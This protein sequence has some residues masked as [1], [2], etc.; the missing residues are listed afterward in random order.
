MECRW[1]LETTAAVDCRVGLQTDPMYHAMLASVNASATVTMQAV[2]V[3]D[4]AVT[5]QLRC[6]YAAMNTS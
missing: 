5:L 4:A 3:A 2:C 1:V 6:N